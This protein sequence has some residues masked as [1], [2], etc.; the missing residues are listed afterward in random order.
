MGVIY[1][2]TLWDAKF[3]RA[4]VQASFETISYGGIGP[5]KKSLFWTEITAFTFTGYG[6]RES[7]ASP[8]GPWSVVANIFDKAN[9][10]YYFAGLAPG[11]TEWWEIVYQNTTGSRET[12]PPLQSTQPPVAS[13]TISQTTSTSAQLVWD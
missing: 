5:T 6:L 3:Q 8:V 7:T 12:I 2:L 1:F 9:T 11:G 4:M 13:L 10:T